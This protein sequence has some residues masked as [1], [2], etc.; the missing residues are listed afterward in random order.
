[1]LCL[2]ALVL[3]ISGCSRSEDDGRTTIEF[4]TYSSGG[5]KDPTG[6]FW[7][8]VARGFERANPG[9]RVSIVYDIPHNY[10]MS[11]LGT[12]FI[13]RNPPDVMLMDDVDVGELAREGMLM[14]LDDRITSDPTYRSDDHAPSMVRDSYVDGRR[15]SVPW[16]GSFVQVTYRTDL[17]ARAGVK[18]PRT[19]DE[20]LAV[21][22]RL[23]QALGMK[24]PFAMSLRGSFWMI[25]W[26]WQNGATVV[27]GDHRRVTVDTPEFVE[28]VQF[29]HDLMHKHAVMDPALT[30]GTKMNDL[31]STGRIAMMLDG[32]FS[33]GRYDVLYP[34]WEGKWA[35]SPLPAGRRDVSFY[36]GAHLV[37]SRI[38]EHPDLAW[39]FMVHATSAETQLLFA[40][41][42]G[43]PPA[44]MKVFDMPAFQTRHPHLAGMRGTIRH[45]RNNP[46]A[47]FFPK[48]WYDLFRNKVVDVVMGDPDADVATAVRAAAKDMQRVADD[49]W[50]RHPELAKGPGR[51]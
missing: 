36:G 29:V 44:N 5:S 25:N 47:P 2:L 17:L 38:T 42:M 34:Q 7:T 30:A 27:S 26:V 24:Y 46:L 10:Y 35:L 43:N 49:Y 20:L 41:M 33:V 8:A 21:C 11:M 19:W 18:P 32:A 14:P 23:Q 40:D 51:P 45:G 15:F 3:L 13:G 50:A 31:W 37:M 6:E 22:R 4:W 48:I 1:M 28:A 16:Y 12:R 39:R 9:V